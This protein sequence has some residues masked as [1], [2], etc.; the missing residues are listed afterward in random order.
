MNQQIAIKREQQVV[1]KVNILVMIG[2]ED[3]PYA[4]KLGPMFASANVRLYDGMVDSLYV[5]AAQMKERGIYRVV[6]TRIDVLLKLLPP[7][8]VK[9]ASIDNYVGSVIPFDGIEFLI[10]PPLKQ[11]VTVEYAEWM[12]G[13]LLTKFTKEESWRKTSEF[14][15]WTLT[16][17]P[18]FNAALKQLAAC[19][20]ISVDTE[21]VKNPRPAIELVQYTGFSFETNESWTYV[22]PMDN[23]SALQ[24]MR[25]ANALM[26]PKVLQNGKYDCAYFFAYNAPLNMYYHDLKNGMHAQYAELPK[27]LA[28]SSALWLRN[29][30]Y[31]KDLSSSGDR[32]DKFRYGALDTWATGEAYISWLQQAPDWAK[33]N[34][35]TE[36]QLMP[37]LHMCEMTGIK[38]D[39]KAL[40]KAAEEG[41]VELEKR[42]QTCRTL[43]GAP[44]FNPSSPLQCVKLICVLT[45]KKW[46][47]DTKKVKDMTWQEQK[48]RQNADKKEIAKVSY[49]HPLNERVLGS[50]LEYRELRKQLSTYLTVGDKEKEFKDRI[51]YSLNQDGTDTGRLASKE[52]HFWCGLNIQNMDG[53]KKIK[54]TF[55]ADEGFHI[56]EADYEQAEDRGVAVKSGDAT[57][58]DIFEKGVDSHSFKASMFFGIPYDEI[59][60]DAVPEYID[61]LGNFHPAVKA[62]KLNVEIRDLAKRVNHGANYNM[63]EGVLL[64]T[65]GPKNVREAQRLLKL[66]AKMTLIEVCRYLL[67]CYER[68]FPTVKKDYYRDIKLLIKRNK[69]L[70]SDTGWTRFCFGNPETSKQALNKYVAHVTQNLNAMILNRAFMA[71]YMK[72]RFNPN[73]KLLAQI[74]DSILFQYRIGHEYLLDEVKELMTFPVPVKDCKGITR[75]LIVPVDVKKLGKNWAGTNE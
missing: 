69:M 10:I 9:K 31:W 44:K 45:G 51:L 60:Q 21:T 23:L 6:T 11:L 53:D 28:F 19:D 24:F 58:L 66:P 18:E 29:I 52:H 12:I 71:I 37:A 59:Y 42:L 34:Y 49:M 14:R 25:Q 46:V 40:Y 68:A 54:Q 47:P 15:W 7:G 22:V 13:H 1:N 43:V 26:I 33:A 61:E 39:M 64:E 2:A 32:Q 35:V 74:H 63:G 73:F 67:I 48:E 36:F 30:M 5:M 38:R 65:M 50:I 41:A 20:L 56:A 70:V 8:R 72:Y 75:D 62:K 17:V 57:L 4:S 3:K 55:I 27:D 16:S